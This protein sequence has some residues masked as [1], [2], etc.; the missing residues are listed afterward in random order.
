MLGLVKNFGSFVSKLRIATS[1]I[2]FTGI[3]QK[4]EYNVILSFCTNSVKHFALERLA[5]SLVRYADLIYAKIH[6]FQLIH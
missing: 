3:H 1:Y 6:I 4:C 5:D 2:D